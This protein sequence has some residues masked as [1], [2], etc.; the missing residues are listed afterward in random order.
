MTREIHSKIISFEDYKGAI[1]KY[2]DLAQNNPAKI[3]IDFPKSE[4]NKSAEA[5]FDKFFTIADGNPEW[6]V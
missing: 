2:D 1:N 5:F 4:H 3:R 6:N